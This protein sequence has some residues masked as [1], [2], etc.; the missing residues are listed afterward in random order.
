MRRT[1]L[2]G[3]FALAGLAAAPALAQESAYPVAIVAGACGDLGEV[4]AELDPALPAEGEA[5]GAATARAA[6]ESFTTVEVPFDTVLDAPHAVVVGEPEAPLVCGDV[7]GFE[8]EDGG[9]TFGLAAEGESELS[10]VA[11]LAPAR[12]GARTFGQVTIVG[13]ERAAE[14][15]GEEPAAGATPEAEADAEA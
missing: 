1:V 2:V 5:V 8:D 6:A 12:R 10:G 3:S 9:V 15:T 7:G 4:V 14:V 13:V 11:Y